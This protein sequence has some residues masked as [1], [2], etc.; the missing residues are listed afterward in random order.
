MCLSVSVSFYICVSVC[1]CLFL[2]LC[3]CLS[4]ADSALISSSLTLTFLSPSY[5]DPCDY[6]RLT[7]IIQYHLPISR[8]LT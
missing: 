8:Y 3:V 4:L 6:I 5:K 2:H 1:L 7:Q